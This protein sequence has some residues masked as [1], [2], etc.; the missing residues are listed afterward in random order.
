MVSLKGF[1]VRSLLTDLICRI[2]AMTTVEVRANEETTIIHR[3]TKEEK[4][5]LKKELW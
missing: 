5:C 3:S 4:A 2:L 1:P